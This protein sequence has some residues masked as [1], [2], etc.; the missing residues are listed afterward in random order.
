VPEPLIGEE[1]FAAGAYIEAGP[2]HAASLRVQD[3]LRWLI[4]IIIL[5][6]GLLKM[7]GLL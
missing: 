7:A 3:I 1:L 6:G 2:L 5:V 4:I